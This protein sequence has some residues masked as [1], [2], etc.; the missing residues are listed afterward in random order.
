MSLHGLPEI[1]CVFDSTLYAMASNFNAFYIL[2]KRTLAAIVCHCAKANRS[3]T[4]TATVLRHWISHKGKKYNTIWKYSWNGFQFYLRLA[5][6]K[7]SMLLSIYNIIKFTFIVGN[8]EKFPNDAK[9]NVLTFSFF[10]RLVYFSS[11]TNFSTHSVLE[12]KK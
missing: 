7:C 3:S 6:T 10:Q 11:K 5:F 4:I 9:Y 1:T 12:N 2:R 8:T